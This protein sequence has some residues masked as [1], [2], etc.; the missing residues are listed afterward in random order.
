VLPATMMAPTLCATVDRMTVATQKTPTRTRSVGHCHAQSDA[1][2]DGA[3]GPQ[4]RVRRMR[5]HGPF[6][7]VV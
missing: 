7:L 3:D 4:Q 2:L 6:V 1:R 5:C